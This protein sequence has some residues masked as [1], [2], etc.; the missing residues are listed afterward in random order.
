MTDK[1]KEILKR[2]DDAYGTEL[3][4]FLHY[5]KPWQLLFSTILSAQCTDRRVN[6]VT[7]ELYQKYGTLRN[8]AEADITELENDIRSTG[9]YHNKAKNIKATARRLLDVYGGKVP[10]S[11]DDLL[12]LPGVGRKTANLIRGHIYHDP[13]IVVDT[14]VGRLSRRLGLTEEKDPKKVEYDLMRELPEDHWIIINTQLIT[15]GRT[16]CTSQRPKCQECFLRDLCPGRQ[17]VPV[18]S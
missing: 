2:L 16:I 8:F 11:L 7:K 15:L 13:A 10:E 3:P 5:E 12:T 17:D 14:H 4:L 9:F 6:E 18:H 1:T